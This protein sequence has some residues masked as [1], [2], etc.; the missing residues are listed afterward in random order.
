MARDRVEAVRRARPAA[1]ARRRHCGRAQARTESGCAPASA[2]T[3]RAPR[4]IKSGASAAGSGS[5]G[6]NVEPS[7]DTPF[8]VTRL[9]IDG[10]PAPR[11]SVSTPASSSAWRGGLARRNS[12]LTPQTGAIGRQRPLGSAI[13]GLHGPP[14]MT[15][16]PAG[17]RRRRSAPRRRARPPTT[18]AR[19]R[20][21]RSA[22]RPRAPGR[23]TRS[24]PRPAAPDSRSRAAP[25]RGRSRAR[26]RARSARAP[27]SRSLAQLGE[28]GPE[29]LD[30]RAP[31]RRP[32]R[33]AAR[34]VAERAVVLDGLVEQRPRAPG[35]SGAGRRRSC[36]PRRRRRSA[37]RSNTRTEAPASAANAASAQPVIPPPMTATSTDDTAGTLVCP[38]C[39]LPRS[40]SPTTPRSSASRCRREEIDAILALAGVAA[41]ASERIAA[42]VACWLAAG[43]ASRS[44]RRAGS[45]T[46]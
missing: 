33:P 45:P 24:W 5:S 12:T 43:P 37:S 32:A 46:S 25:P 18:R 13:P 36:A 41:H 26:A 11:I 19:A 42:P 16:A 35:P 7:A 4:S 38:S 10:G 1:G 40:G 17:M 8:A 14:A 28:P 21:R 20:P 3:K 39:R 6:R 27:S 44:T 23:R 29:R 31:A 15:T 22:R 34:T 30:A 2:G 9:K